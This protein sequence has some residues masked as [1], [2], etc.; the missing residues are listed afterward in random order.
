VLQVLL[1]WLLVQV[2]VLQVQVLWL[3]VQVQV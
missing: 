1:L 2:W 3:L